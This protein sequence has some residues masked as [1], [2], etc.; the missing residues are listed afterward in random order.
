MRLGIGSYTYGWA[1]GIE[2]DRPDGAF[3]AADLVRRA[4][5]LG[6]GVVQLCDNL[7]PGTWEDRSVEALAGQAAAAGV[8]LEVGTR[9]CEISHL[10]RFARIARRL[11]SPILRVV[12]DTQGDHP[13]PAEVVRRVATVGPDLDE[14]GVTL[15]VENHDRFRARTLEGIILELRELG[16]RAGI[17]LDTVNSFGALE[18][19]E[20]VVETLGP[21]VCCL[22]LKDFAVTRLPHLQ[23]FSVEGRPAGAGMLD[24]PWLLGRLGGVGRDFSAILEL[25]TPPEPD[26]AGTIAKEAEWA[27]Q[28]VRAARQ[29]INQ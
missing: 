18:G 12:V 22:H 26:R 13:S 27:A 8:A 14:A 4:R 19:P 3:T 5:E 1:V 29:W 7:P 6:V 25:W 21:Y 28:S 10:R 17:C 20:V 2:G 23:G 16:V 11:G 24:I 15:A 9:G